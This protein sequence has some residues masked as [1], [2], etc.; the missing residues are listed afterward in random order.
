M[1][2]KTSLV[3]KRLPLDT[4]AQGVRMT[5]LTSLD[6]LSWF[7]SNHEMTSLTVVTPTLQEP[8]HLFSGFSH[9]HC[10]CTQL[11][12]NHRRR[13]SRTPDSQFHTLHSPGENRLLN[14]LQIGAGRSF[15]I[16]PG[17]RIE[18][19][20]NRPLCTAIIQFSTLPLHLESNFYKLWRPAY[21]FTGAK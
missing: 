11:V 2:L 12:R 21:H 14:Y 19:P 8:I 3:L 5:H 13:R 10:P 4:E 15:H 7:D 18:W 17:R 20:T 6:Y 9:W 16:T 1:V